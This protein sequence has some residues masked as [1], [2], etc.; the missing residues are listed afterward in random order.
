MS[1]PGPARPSV[2]VVDDHALLAQ[3]L[4]VVLRLHG[5]GAVEHLSGDL[6]AERVLGAA[7]ARRPDV[8]LLDLHLGAAGLG[9]PLVAP[10]KALP[11]TVLML[12]ASQDRRLLAE[13]LEEGAD[14]LFD[15]ARPL[16]QLADDLADAARGRSV[17]VPEARAALLDE[18]REHRRSESARQRLLAGLTPREGEI[19]AELMD[20]R[21]A[22]RI[23]EEGAVSPNTVRTQIKSI[24]RKLGVNSQLAAVALAH[25]AGWRLS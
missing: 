22:D 9:L 12:T 6:D 24:L 11:A 14:G 15:K 19:L 8:V 2:L 17:L 13:C 25:S 7:R 5:F 16:E 4:A 3:C 18:L 21:S 1:P 20:G 23:A 10:L